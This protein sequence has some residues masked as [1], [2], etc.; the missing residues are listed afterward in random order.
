MGRWGKGGVRLVS[1]RQRGEM[2]VLKTPCVSEAGEESSAVRSGPLRAG[3]TSRALT[4]CWQ[5][6]CSEQGAGLLGGHVGEVI[7]VQTG[8]DK[9]TVRETGPRAGMERACSLPR[10]RRTRVPRRVGAG[11][12]EGARGQRI[13]RRGAGRAGCEAGMGSRVQTRDLL[14][15]GEWEGAAVGPGHR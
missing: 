6:G 8:W 11:T 12:Q 9:G 15:C 14:A 4:G 2:G 5:A 3:G 10:I 7:R 1:V 13:S